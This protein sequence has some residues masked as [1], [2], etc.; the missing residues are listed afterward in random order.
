MARGVSIKFQSYESTIPRLLELI[1][2][3]NE[4]KKYDKVI[5]KPYLSTNEATNT[6]LEFVEEVLK[7][8]LANKHPVAELFIAEGSDGSNTLELFNS[9]GYKKLAEKYSIGLIDL[10]ET[11]TEAIQDGEF[12]RF[13]ELHYP[14]ILKDAFIISLTSLFE[15]PETEMHG[16]LT[17]MLGA[18]PANKYQGFFSSNKNKIRK[19]PIKFSIHDILKVKMPQF[20]LIDVSSKGTIIAGHPLE[21]DKKAATLLGK[22]WRTIPH[23]KLLDES[24]GEKI[25]KAPLN[26]SNT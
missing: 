4:L 16:A 22:E 20:A 14:R 6:K 5:I 13:E 23:L 1:K 15:N 10:N 9:L 26:V 18:F 7:F 12:L 8:C 11:E 17:N 24:F 2:L 21:A 25:V 19:W 3:Q